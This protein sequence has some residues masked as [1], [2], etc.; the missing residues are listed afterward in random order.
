MGAKIHTW[1]LEII[2]H[3]KINQTEYLVILIGFLLLVFVILFRKE[4]N[5]YWILR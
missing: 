4:V 3:I 2:S 5:H 1:S